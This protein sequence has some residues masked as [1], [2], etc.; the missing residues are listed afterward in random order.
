MRALSKAVLIGFTLLFM[1]GV[2][3]LP[4]SLAAT[5]I[6]SD[7]EMSGVIGKGGISITVDHLTT[8]THINTIYYGDSDGWGENTQAGYISLNDVTLKGNITFASPARVELGTAIGGFGMIQMT[9]MKLSIPD[10]VVTIDR[11]AVGAIRMGSKPG[12]GTSMGSCG[13]TGFSARITG[14]TNLEVQVQ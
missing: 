9:N 10:A 14:G 11:F 4:Q 5:T 13:L 2:I 7:E 3:Y 12:T 6:L 8:D 1:V